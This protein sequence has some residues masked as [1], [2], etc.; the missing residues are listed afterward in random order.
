MRADA[1]LD[2]GTARPREMGSLQSYK[3]TWLH[4]CMGEFTAEFGWPLSKILRQKCFYS[5]VSEFS[6]HQLYAP[7]A[8]S[9]FAKRGLRGP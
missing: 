2:H 4:G 8:T 6:R 5:D 7:V 1:L 3:V 9:S